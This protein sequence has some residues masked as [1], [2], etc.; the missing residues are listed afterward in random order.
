MTGRITITLSQDHQ[1]T[2][3]P[4]VIDDTR[5]RPTLVGEIIVSGDDE[6]QVSKIATGDL[7]LTVA[8]LI[9]HERGQLIEDRGGK[10]ATLDA[11]A[12]WDS[13]DVKEKLV[14]GTG[15]DDK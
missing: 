14:S 8:A 1:R 6:D 3:E 7:D 9:T 15:H 10:G 2:T 11:D 4:T 12:F 5:H 13:R